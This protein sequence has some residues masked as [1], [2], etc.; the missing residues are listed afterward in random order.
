MFMEMFNERSRLLHSYVG[1]NENQAIAIGGSVSEVRL[2]LKFLVPYL[3]SALI[4]DSSCNTV[5]I[6]QALSPQY[7]LEKKEKE[8]YSGETICARNQGG[9]SLPLCKEVL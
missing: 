9:I 1:K 4:L 5:S 2:A 3:P 8:N 7:F 6:Y